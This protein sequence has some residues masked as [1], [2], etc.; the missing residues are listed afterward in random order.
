M[1]V[2]SPLKAD[3]AWVAVR[4]GFCEVLLGVCGALGVVPVAPA[5]T[6][7]AGAAEGTAAGCLVHFF[8]FCH[9][10]GG[11]IRVAAD[12]SSTVC[13][14]GCR[15]GGDFE[16]SLAWCRPFYSGPHS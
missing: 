1:A 11:A 16:E 6:G 4:A 12:D 8:F 15:E 5:V 10:L 2:V 3:A 13:T 9:F 14:S 7:Y